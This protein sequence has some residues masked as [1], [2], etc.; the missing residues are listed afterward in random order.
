MVN[1]LLRQGQIGILFTR[2]PLVTGRV[3]PFLTQEHLLH[4]EKTVIGRL[5][6]GAKVE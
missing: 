4:F 2:V 1:Y 5:A 6:V 3:P